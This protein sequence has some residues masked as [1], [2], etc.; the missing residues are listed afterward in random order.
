MS[1]EEEKN[2]GIKK[3]K[4]DE[5]L[6][7]VRLEL[8]T[9]RDDLIYE[10]DDLH[11]DLKDVIEDLKDE[12][13]DIKDNLKDELED[14]I[15][16]R[17]ELL[18]EVGDIKDELEQYGEDAKEHIEHAK[19]KLDVLK[20]KIERHEA[21]FNEKIQKKI[22]KAK[23]KVSRI[24]ISV[25]PEMSEEWRDWADGLGA[26]VSELVR[27]SMKFVK[28]N[29]G[30]LKKLEQLG[31][32][33]EKMGEG[34]EQAV[35]ESG[36]EE[37]GEKLESKFGDRKEKGKSKI[38]IAVKQ[39][40]NKE[41]IKKRVHGLIKL[42]NSLPIEK[43]AQALGKSNEDAENLIYEM[44]AEGVEGTLEE[45]VFKFTSDSEEVITILDELIDKMYG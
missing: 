14:I 21:K 24:N 27:K 2:D 35:K 18:D 9:I 15:E 8:N 26:S 12:A 6:G 44:V 3:E 32:K 34:I 43:L 31:V 45:S 23:R 38:H 29:I 42:H 19:E 41:R 33:M 20:E 40:T 11:D 16:E 4:N 17:E 28:N 36:I 5:D 7:K 39:N 10:L 37:L 30:D 1:N 25:D 13:V 22:E